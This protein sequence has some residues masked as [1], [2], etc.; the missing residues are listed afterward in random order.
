MQSLDLHQTA[1]AHLASS[2]T[3]FKS[4]AE[5][6]ALPD[7]FKHVAPKTDLSEEEKTALHNVTSGL[8]NRQ[9]VREV[10]D[11]AIRAVC[12]SLELPIPDKKAKRK[13]GQSAEETQPAS[14][15][16]PK[17]DS[18]PSD[19]ASS[20]KRR[21]EDDAQAAADVSDSDESFKGF[22]DAEDDDGTDGDEEDNSEMEEGDEETAMARYESMLGGSDD[23]SGGEGESREDLRAKYAALL[24]MRGDPTSGDE[25]EEDNDDLSDGPSDDEISGSDDDDDDKAADD[26]KPKRKAAP[27]PRQPSLSPS[28]PPTKKTKEAKA[29]KAGS[30]TFLPSL[31]GG[32]LSGS[33]SASDIDIAPKKRL[34]QRQRQAIAE[35]KHGERAN[36]VR[37]QAEKQ[38]KG[39]DAGWDMRRG[40]VDGDDQGGKGRQPWKKGGAP[41]G[42]GG[43]GGRDGPRRQGGQQAKSVSDRKKPQTSRDDQGPLHPSWQARKKAKETEHVAF[44]GTKI[45]F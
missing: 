13:K 22:S 15:E 34:G 21:I 19:P 35:R 39:R 33:E 17:P 30:T 24:G 20:K 41:G 10:V 32:Y 4:I 5:H 29:A 6:P 43:G 44:Q 8:Y 2:L 25:S 12:L 16:T 31:M 18:A 26:D 36:H 42:G 3:R 45:K 37:K 9:N 38:K 14:E 27:A 28:P 23:E 11:K 1:H 40:A 7:D